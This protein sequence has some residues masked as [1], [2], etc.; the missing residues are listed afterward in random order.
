MKGRRSITYTPLTIA[1]LDRIEMGGSIYAWIRRKL[2]IGH[3]MAYVF[4]ALM[5]VKKLPKEGIRT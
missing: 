1:E 4:D 2:Q 5:A 3:G